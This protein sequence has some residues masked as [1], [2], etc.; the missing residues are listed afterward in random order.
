METKAKVVD[1]TKAKVVDETADVSATPKSK[2]TEATVEWQGQVRT[3][4]K[5]DHGENFLELAKEFAEKK[6]GEIVA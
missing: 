1:E 2:K 5:E 6:G 3:Y 4:T